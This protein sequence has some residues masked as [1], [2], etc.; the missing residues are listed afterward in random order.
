M[1]LVLYLSFV[2]TSAYHGSN[3]FF[4]WTRV[5]D[6]LKLKLTVVC[7]TI[8]LLVVSIAL[9]TASTQKPIGE[10]ETRPKCSN[11]GTGSIPDCDQGFS[12]L[13][14]YKFNVK[15]SGEIDATCTFSCPFDE[16][17]FNF[18]VSVASLALAM[19]VAGIVLE[20][21]DALIYPRSFLAGWATLAISACFFAVAVV[22]ADAARKGNEWCMNDFKFGGGSYYN[23]ASSGSDLG[24]EFTCEPGEFVGVFFA[25]VIC[26]ALAWFVFVGLASRADP[27]AS[28]RASGRPETKRRV[29]SA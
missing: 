3:Q 27:N 21:Y 2:S 13:T 20:Y 18:R 7:L 5:K 16:A 22:D 4:C 1:S 28:V 25:D 10:Q 8:V 19:S 6:F 9:I 23:F 26:A 17:N 12:L 24:E 15:L 11:G 14:P 29:G